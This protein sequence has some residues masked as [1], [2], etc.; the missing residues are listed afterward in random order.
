MIVEP[1]YFRQVLYKNIEQQTLLPGDILCT[2]GFS[3]CSLHILRLSLHLYK[4][5][6]YMKLLIVLRA[7]S[8]YV[9]PCSKPF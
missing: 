6:T 4:L 1:K 2:F 9:H 3:N 5:Y 7:G 8:L